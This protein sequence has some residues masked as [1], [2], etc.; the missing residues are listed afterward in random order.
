[1]IELP[2]VS[3]NP[4]GLQFPELE[5]ATLPR[6][7]GEVD[8]ALINTN[9]ALD[10]KLNPTHDALAIEDAKSPYVNF[11]VGKPGSA[12]DS[13]VIKLVAALR[14]EAVRGFIEIHYHGAVVPA[15]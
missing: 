3:R 11:L 8:L 9:Y 14:S 1:M 13:Q 10:A 15:V 2:S 12:A 7:L 4:K 6:M 5:A